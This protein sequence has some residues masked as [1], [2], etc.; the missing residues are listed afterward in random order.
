MPGTALF[1]ITQPFFGAKTFNV[2]AWVDYSRVIWQKRVRWE[3]QLRVQNVM[4]NRNVA[5]WTAVDDGTG[6]RFVEQRLL[7]S[8]L[9][10][11][12]SSTFRF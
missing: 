10:V 11:S 2:D 1:D 3:A 9:G 6:G 4:N 8:A 5:P 12:L 7:P